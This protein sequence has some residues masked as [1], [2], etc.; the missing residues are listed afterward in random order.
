MLGL[1]LFVVPLRVASDYVAEVHQPRII[2]EWNNM[3]GYK[4]GSSLAKV[5]TAVDGEVQTWMKN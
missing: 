1:T 2:G 5:Y 4:M 3:I